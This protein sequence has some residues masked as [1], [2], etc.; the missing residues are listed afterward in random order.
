MLVR[1]LVGLAGSQQHMQRTCHDDTAIKT[2][3]RS[4]ALHQLCCALNADLGLVQALF[5]VR[6]LV[7]GRR[8]PAAHAAAH[9][10][11]GRL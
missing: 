7:G 6:V 11:W 9:C 2:G 5:R 3:H 10:R 8:Q 4:S 1:M